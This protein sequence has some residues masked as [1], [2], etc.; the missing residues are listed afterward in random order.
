[1]LES[2]DD[3]VFALTETWLDDT[4]RDGQIADT[5]RYQI[6]RK[7]R[8]TSRG[9][10]V[11]VLAPSHIICR[12]RADL[13]QDNLEAV[14]VELRTPR[15]KFLLACIYIAPN[16]HSSRFDSLQTSIDKLLELSTSYAS[17]Y[18]LGDFNVHIDW[19]DLSSPIPA[20]P[21]SQQLLEMVETAGLV[22]LCSD[23]TYRSAAGNESQL[24]L[25]FTTNPTL[26]LDCYAQESLVGSDHK[27]IHIECYTSLPRQG[28]FSRIIYRY[29]KTDLS[30]LRALLHLAPWSMV[31]SEP[32]THEMYDLWTDFMTAIQTECVP[33]SPAS[34]KK[35]PPWI[36]TDIVKLARRKRLLFNRARKQH[37]ASSYTKTRSLQKDIKRLVHK[38]HQEYVTSIAAR[39]AKE[40]K[41]FWAYVKSQRK[42]SSPGHPVFKHNQKLVSDPNTI[43][44]LFSEHFS[45]IWS[46]HTTPAF[47]PRKPLVP[48]LASPSHPANPESSPPPGASLS[49]LSITEQDL[50]E[51]LTSLRP[52][53]NPGPD[54]VHPAFLQLS[55]P[56]TKPILIH[57]FQRILDSGTVPLEWKRS[58]ITPI[59]KGNGLDTD[60]IDS[61][62]PIASTSVVSRTLE[63]IVN[64][65][66][67]NHLEDNG[68]QN[69][70]QHGFRRG[71]S[72]DTALAVAV[73]TLSS[74][75]DQRIPCQLVQLDFSKAFDR[76]DH[77]LLP[78][79]LQKVGIEGP[80]ANW[81]M[82]F[83]RNRT[84][85]V[86]F[87]GHLSSPCTVLAGVPQGSVLGPTL[88]SLYINDITYGL[89]SKAILYADD[90]F[91][92]QPGISKDAVTSL[93]NDLDACYRWSVTHS[94]PLNPTKCLSMTVSLSLA[95][96]SHSPP[97]AIGGTELSRVTHIKLLGVEF[98]ERL[99]FSR[100]IQ[101]TASRARRTLGFV[102]QITRGMPAAP[103]RHLY[104][105]LVLPQLEFCSAIWDPPSTTHKKSLE[106]IQ[107]RAA[108][109]LYRRD[110]PSSHHT[111]ARDIPTTRLLQYTQWRTLQ[112]RRDVA[113]I[114][115]FCIMMGAGHPD[116][117]S[118]PRLNKRTGRLQPPLSRTLRHK[119][120]CLMRAAEIWRSLPHHLTES[121][122]YFHKALRATRRALHSGN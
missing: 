1:M 9:G 6:F 28:H 13:E 100:H 41:L 87:H 7:D 38:S 77:A 119:T 109:T 120:L 91:L 17:V 74:H 12:R 33:H 4:T 73:H 70:A 52:A 29:G 65:K 36:T 55:A 24:D 114:R 57:M 105:S 45:S 110:S 116:V 92:I 14:F 78:K 115:L 84:Q 31:L 50:E 103:L 104:T 47:L 69:Q 108:L 59:H 51:S 113:S 83:I 35:R 58:I 68:L 5:T 64:N 46:P 25:C 90:L 16:T 122:D 80:L 89:K 61:Y 48:P 98:D 99:D 40:P 72:C 81:L 106:S 56:L 10:G 82:D 39:A 62:R 67:L 111:A 88:F 76:I 85:R 117:P 60:S 54:R 102:T 22:Q 44:S 32:S 20:D 49:P 66:I 107:R 93:Q 53:Q 97:L 8:S 101:G 63:R 42:S 11:M 94:L 18:L 2:T 21:A 19:R 27:A 71:R 23:P 112:H 121:I 96:P 37:C 30:H 79:K 3:T 34:K 86:A 15:S 75:L 43:A 118:P 26:L 95:K